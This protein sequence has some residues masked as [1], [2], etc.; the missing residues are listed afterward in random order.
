[1][2]TVPHSGVISSMNVMDKEISNKYLKNKILT[3][4]YFSLDEDRY[5]YKI[6]KDKIKVK[7]LN[8]QLL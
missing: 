7:K 8:F 6:V 3:P 1:M 2:N 5:T 4:K